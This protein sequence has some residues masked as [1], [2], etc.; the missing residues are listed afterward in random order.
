MELRP[1]DT[2]DIPAIKSLS[3]GIWGGGDYLPRIIGDWI[4]EGGVYVGLVH[5][6]IV[7]V[8]RIHKL[9]D[10]EWWLEGLRIAVA[11]QGHGYGR[12]L[13][14]LTLEELKRIG[15]GTV[16]F[17]SADTNHSIPPALKSGF[18]EILRLPFA[19]AELAHHHT[20]KHPWQTVLEGKQVSISN[21]ATPRVKDLLQTACQKDYNGLIR[22][23][24]EFYNYNIE[25][26]N[27]WLAQGVVLTT[28]VKGNVTAA[29]VLSTD[30]ERPNNWDLNMLA[31][32]ES[33]IRE[34]IL[35]SLVAAAMLQ[36]EH[37][38]AIYACVPARYHDSLISAGFQSADFF[39]YQIVFEAELARLMPAY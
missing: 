30:Y 24:W 10:D 15:K 37:Y 16:R 35:P 3:E 32:D 2:S 20:V 28:S 6:A 27:S 25:R 21:E 14:N 12:D 13:H 36:P 22:N 5:G 11:H 18:H 33:A 9:A 31:G 19:F 7:G 1:A 29:A 26:L 39:S 38:N 34:Q 8:S 23:G 17:A 4:S